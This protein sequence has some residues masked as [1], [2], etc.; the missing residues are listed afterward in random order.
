MSRPEPSVR[1]VQDECAIIAADLENLIQRLVRARESLRLP[2]D[3]LALYENEDTGRR[4]FKD[5]AGMAVEFAFAEFVT[6]GG[7]SGLARSAAAAVA[8]VGVFDLG[9]LRVVRRHHLHEL[10]RN[11]FCGFG[12]SGDHHAHMIIN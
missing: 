2:P 7:G 4:F 10:R 5:L 3:T 6:A 9:G 12:V 11:N 1:D 8:A